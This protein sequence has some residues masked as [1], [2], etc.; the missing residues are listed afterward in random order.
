M[1][2]ATTA[3]ALVM[4]GVGRQIILIDK[5]R[6]R[7]SAEAEDVSHAVPFSHPLLVTD[8]DYEDLKGSRLV[9]I[10]AGVSQRPGESRLNLLKR[11]AAVFKEV[12]SR[13]LENEP[14][15][16][17]LVASNPV[18][19]MTHL[20]AHYASRFGI[21]SHRVIGSGTTLDTARFR[22]LL[23]SYVN[24]D[25]QHIHGYVIGEHGDSEVLTWSA[26]RIGAMTL[27]DFCNQQNICLD[28]DVHKDIDDKVRNAAYR[29]I[30][31]K[32]ATYY[33]VATALAKIADAVL[34]DQRC[35][36]TVTTPAP[37]VAGISDVSVS[38]PRLVGGDG[39]LATFQCGLDD[40]EQEALQGSARV[41]REAI[42]ELGEDV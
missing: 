42:D 25:S 38:L 36:L 19:I 6:K 15:A 22:T 16:I 35:I 8:G 29:I 1:V 27:D 9:V 26:L 5:D 3:H 40:R 4:R 14:G 21:P 39:V 17:L 41:V 12:V 10:S 18:D 23:G 37:T 34:R 31:G 11:N 24:T 20:T 30:N 7:A 33:G 32:G 13:I 2:G 28:S